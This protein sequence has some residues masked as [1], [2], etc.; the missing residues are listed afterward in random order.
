MI[1]QANIDQIRLL[2]DRIKKN[3]ATIEDYNAYQTLLISFG[4]TESDFKQYLAKESLMTYDELIK[5]RAKF[6]Q[7]KRDKDIETVVV[8]GLIALGLAVIISAVLDS[9]K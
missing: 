1:N 2:Q 9:R 5:E 7:R 8:A 4:R 3:I 6:V